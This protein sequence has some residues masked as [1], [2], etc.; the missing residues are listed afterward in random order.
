MLEYRRQVALGIVPTTPPKGR[1]WTITVVAIIVAVTALVVM[2]GWYLW[3]LLDAY[4]ARAPA[5]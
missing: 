1:W 2:T 4:S 3:A 5:P